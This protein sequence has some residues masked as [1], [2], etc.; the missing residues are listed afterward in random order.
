[1]VEALPKK[2]VYSVPGMDKVKAYK[3]LLYKRTKDRDLLADV[4]VP[5]NLAQ[6]ESR[7]GVIF[8]HGGYL[9]PNLLTQPKDWGVFKSYGQLVAASGFVGITFN[10]RYYGR[11]HLD[12]AQNDII[13]LVDYVREHAS[14][15]SLDK[16]RL[17]VWAFSG[18]GPLISWLIRTVPA[19]LRVLVLYYSI[20]ELRPNPPDGLQISDAKRLEFS[21]VNQ[22]NVDFAQIG[23]ELQKT[24]QKMNF[25]N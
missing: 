9:P 3:D 1:M 25:N 7:P 2:V 14:E 10:H 21:P 13:D 5:P 17:C 8:V 22:L 11:D 19:Y 12:I 18:G 24:A 20:L 16:D 23:A 15:F 6:G 4:Y